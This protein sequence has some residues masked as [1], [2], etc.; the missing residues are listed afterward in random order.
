MPGIFPRYRLCK[1]TAAQERGARWRD[2]PATPNP[3]GGCTTVSSTHKTWRKDGLCMPAS[4]EKVR[5]DDVRGVLRVGSACACIVLH[6]SRAPD[7]SSLYVCFRRVDNSLRTVKTCVLQ[8]KPTE[9][10]EQSGGVPALELR[11]GQGGTWR[12]I[13]VAQEMADKRNEGCPSF[14][15]EVACRH[16]IH[17]PS[18]PRPPPPRS[19]FSTPPPLLC[20]CVCVW[21]TRGSATSTSQTSQQ[22]T[23]VSFRSFSPFQEALEFLLVGATHSHTNKHTRFK[24]GNT[25]S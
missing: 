2:A 3:I 9:G 17:V 21:R 14:L 4:R 16:V 15:S 11:C 5:A 20:R 22:H 7:L 1:P 12:P 18:R 24:M 6:R 25:G 23:S 19:C 8:T 13:G 10:T